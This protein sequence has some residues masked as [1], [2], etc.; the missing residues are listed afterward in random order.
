MSDIGTRPTV[1]YSPEDVKYR[2]KS[3][4]SRMQAALA[5]WKT[6]ARSYLK[7]METATPRSPFPDSPVAPVAAVMDDQDSE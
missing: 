3:S 5:N 6:T 7:R 4:W 2:T 1:I